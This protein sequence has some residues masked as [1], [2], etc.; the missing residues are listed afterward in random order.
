MIR[1]YCCRARAVAKTAPRPVEAPVTRAR[2]RLVSC[3]VAV[4]A[5][6]MPPQAFPK[7]P[8]L[9]FPA[10]AEVWSMSEAHTG[11]KRAA[12]PPVPPF[13]K[14]G[15]RGNFAQGGNWGATPKITCTCTHSPQ[16]DV[17][18]EI[19]YNPPVSLV[20]PRLVPVLSQGRALHALQRLRPC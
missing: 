13:D 15:R 3:T 14:G 11:C 12:N 6:S 4:C 9:S 7:T 20:W 10:C 18:H 19:R 16:A 17:P 1:S 2:H 5:M 8:S